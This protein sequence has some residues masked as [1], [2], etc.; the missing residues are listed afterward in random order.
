M[1]VLHTCGFVKST[2][3][4]PDSNSSRSTEPWWKQFN[5]EKKKRGFIYLFQ[6]IKY[7][8]LWDNMEHCLSDEND[9]FAP[10]WCHDKAPG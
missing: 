7:H 1:P 4:V 5:A 6:I 8:F 10:F 3:S 9:A 2:D